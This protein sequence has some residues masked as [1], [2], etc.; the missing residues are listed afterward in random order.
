MIYPVDRVI[1]LSNNWGLVIYGLYDTAEI[2]HFDLPDPG[3][4]GC[5]I[6]L[7][8]F[9]VRCFNKQLII[10]S[11]PKSMP[12]NFHCLVLNL[13]AD[14][15]SKN[16]IKKLTCNLSLINDIICN[17]QYIFGKTGQSVLLAFMVSTMTFSKTVLFVLISSGLCGCHTH[18][19]LDDWKKTLYLYIVPNGI[20]IVVPM[21]CMVATG[22]IMLSSMKNYETKTTKQK[23]H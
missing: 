13:H 20:W 6:T 9:L 2:R 14:K 3:P 11:P 22:K 18:V 23:H 5:D 10:H 4:C 15:V 8:I 17:F 21:L 12:N 16:D 19:S 1:H 7:T